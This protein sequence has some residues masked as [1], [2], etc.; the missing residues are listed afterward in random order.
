MG[1]YERERPFVQQMLDLAAIVPDQITDPKV[2]LQ[3]ESGLDVR[4]LIGGRTIGIQVTEYDA[5]KGLP[6]WASL[7][8]KS[9]ARELKLAKE[10][11]G[12]YGFSVSGEYIRALKSCLEDKL[13]KTFAWVD[14]GWLLIAAQNPKYGATSS[15]FVAAEHVSIERLNAELHPLLSGKQYAK[16]F[17]LL[18][19]QQVLF[20]WRPETQW[21]CQAD[22]RRTVDAQRVETLRK[23]LLG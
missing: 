5:D 15:T 6:S 22:L 14:E 3:D 12:G 4:C 17:L 9:R 13:Q 7:P 1:S 10:K 8:E 18:S 19:L 20:E 11:P 16:A 2:E 21:R 23:K